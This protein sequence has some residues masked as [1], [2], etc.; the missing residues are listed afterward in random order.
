MTPREWWLIHKV[1]T[2]PRMVGSL[3]EVETENL[4]E[5]LDRKLEG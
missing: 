5:M 1:K 3:T 4:L 2:P